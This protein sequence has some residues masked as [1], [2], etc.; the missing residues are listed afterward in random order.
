MKTAQPLPKA[1]DKIWN[2]GHE[3]IVT[4][5]RVHEVKNSA[6]THQFTYIGV[7]T[8][9]PSNDSIR[10]TGFNGGTYGFGINL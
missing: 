9:D 8:D 6:F 4:E 5:P 10:N 1:G 3:F 7:C 2:H